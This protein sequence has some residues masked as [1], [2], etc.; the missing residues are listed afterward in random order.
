MIRNLPI[1]RKLILLLLAASGITLLVTA[2]AILVYELTSFRSRTLDQV[3]AQAQNAAVTLHAPLNFLIPEDTREALEEAIERQRNL[4]GACVYLND[5]EPFAQYQRGTLADFRCPTLKSDPVNRFTDNTLELYHRIQHDGEAVG[6]LYLVARLPPLAERVPQY[7][8]TVGTVLFALFTVSLL[9]LTSLR[10]TIS[11]PIFELAGAAQRVIEVEDYGIRV[12]VPS[13]DEIG[14]LTISFN[15][16]LAV[17]QQRD[18]DLR[19][20]NQEQKNLQ[21]QLL[22]AQKMESIGRLAGGV[23]HDF[24]NLLTVVV[25]CTDLARHHLPKESPATPLLDNIRNATRQATDLT[26]QLLAFARR[27]IIE[28]RIISLN[29]LVFEAEKMLHTLIGEDI[30]L[31]VIPRR[32][33]WPVKADP[34]QMLQVLVNLVVNARDAMPQGGTLTIETSNQII[35]TEDLLNHPEAKVGDFAVFSVKDTGTGLSEEARR[36]LFEPFFTTK[37]R[38]KG[39]GLGLAMCY[40]IVTQSGGHIQFDSRPGQGTTFEVYLR[41]AL[42]TRPLKRSGRAP[43][44][45]PTGE[46]TILV[47]EDNALVRVTAVE[48]LRAQGYTVLEAASGPDALRLVEDYEKEIHLLL[49]D[50]VM[51]EMNGPEVARHVQQLR[52]GIHVLY[53]SGYT[54][55]EIGH[56]G[57]L[58]PGMSFLQKPYT[59]E[60]LIHKV[61]RILDAS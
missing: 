55:D 57:E 34:S 52:P 41:R 51:P 9:L 18:A 10:R 36:H 8:L 23:A 19:R 29:D 12:D 42:E 14:N 28:P 61:R 3:E 60:T 39:T 26:Q 44:H 5:R 53:V 21:E 20:A 24:N 33:L 31:V 43:L 17:I 59:S 32:D 48:L 35:T 46:E 38:G 15:R 4:L 56:R 58:D 2:G 49:T 13:G 25:G 50:V 1:G 6:T 7:F 16:M 47:V 27:Q 40:G 37:E 22:Q 11:D 54:A 30:E 45:L